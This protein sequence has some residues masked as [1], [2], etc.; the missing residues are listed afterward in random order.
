MQGMA[1]PWCRLDAVES[2]KIALGAK[3]LRSSIRIKKE[4]ADANTSMEDNIQT[5]AETAPSLHISFNRSKGSEVQA[6]H[7]F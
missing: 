4:T 7:K 6:D 2:S 1:C 3:P 5:E